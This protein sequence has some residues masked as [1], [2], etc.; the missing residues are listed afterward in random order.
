MRQRSSDLHIAENCGIIEQLLVG[1]P[2]LADCGFSVEVSVGLHDG[3]LWPSM[4]LVC[5]LSVYKV[6]RV[7]LDSCSSSLLPVKSGVSQDSI[8]GPLLFLV[9]VNDM[10]SV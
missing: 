3:H 4:E 1:N 10:F 2:I 5:K 7:S 6:H 8:L 9:Y